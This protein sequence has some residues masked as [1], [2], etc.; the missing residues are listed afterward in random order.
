MRLTRLDAENVARK[1]AKK[2]A[3]K[4]VEKI[5]IANTVDAKAVVKEE[6][7]NVIERHRTERGRKIYIN[8]HTRSKMKQPFKIL[9]ESRVAFL[10]IAKYLSTRRIRKDRILRS[11]CSLREFE[12]CFITINRVAV[13]KHSRRLATNKSF[14]GQTLPSETITLRKTGV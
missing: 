4:T 1:T 3:K 12:I 10:D 11:E 6:P 9:I 14:L 5:A 13:C 2:T 7:S 8:I